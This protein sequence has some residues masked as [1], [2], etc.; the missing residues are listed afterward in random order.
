MSWEE[1]G[2]KDGDYLGKD[3]ELHAIA[4]QCFEIVAGKY[5][6]EMC[7]FGKAE[8]KEGSKKSGTKLGT[9]QGIEYIDDLKEHDNILGS[10][11][12]LKWDKGAKCWNGPKRSATVYMTCGTEN[13]VISANEPDTCRYV[14]EMESYLA[15]DDEYKTKLGLWQ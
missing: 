8:Q 10:T 6:Y 15:C 11:R 1:I 12:V 4:E 14:F 2:G 7:I 3:G 9:W 5:T 13:R